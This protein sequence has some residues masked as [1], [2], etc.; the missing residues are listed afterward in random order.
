MLPT[1]S[2]NAPAPAA[3]TANSEFASSPLVLPVVDAGAWWPPP[4]PSVLSPRSRRPPNASPPKASISAAPTHDQE[5]QSLV[6]VFN[7]LLDRD[8]MGFR[9]ARHF[10]ADT[11]HELKNPLALLHAELEQAEREAPSGS[12]QHQVY[13]SLLDDIRHLKA[14]LEKLLLLSLAESGR[15]VVER[16]TTDRSAMRRNI[17]EDSEDR[18]AGRARG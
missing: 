11:S 12:P 17:A 16:S 14:I 3:A 7:A 5:F 9:Q 18:R 1:G 8:E 6:T 2:A 13:S 15:L 4:A 10:S